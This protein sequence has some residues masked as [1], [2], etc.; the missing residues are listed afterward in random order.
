MEKSRKKI[1]ESFES[2]GHFVYRNSI[3]VLIIMTLGIGFLVS[4]LP[5]M[6]MD[7]SIEG[8]LKENS[9]VR[10]AYDAFKE[11]YGRDELILLA[12]KGKNVFTVPFLNKLQKLH[13][14]IEDTI[15]HLDDITSLVN[16]RNTYGEGDELR[17]D[18][19]LQDWDGTIDKKALE[20]LRTQAMGN[21]VYKNMLLSEDGTFTTIIVKTDAFMS[22]GQASEEDILEG[23]DVDN[24]AHSG[25]KKKLK[26]LSG[27][28]NSAIVNAI[29]KI[30]KKYSSPDF[31][32]YYAGSPV[33]EES[34]KN[35]MHKDMQKFMGLALLMISFFL[36]LMF[37]RVSGVFLPVL[38]VVL[39]LL[40]TLSLMAWFG[41]AIK[42][43]TQILPSFLLAV[44]VG[45]A[46]HIM[47]IFYRKLSHNN[48][49]KED[50]IAYALGHSGLAVVMTSLTTAGGL[51]S[52]TS[53]DLAPIADIGMYATAGVLL[54]LTY[55]IILLPALLAVIP[56][57]PKSDESIH[58]KKEAFLDRMLDRIA[59]LSTHHAKGV[60]LISGGIMII[61]FIGAL[62]LSFSHNPLTWFPK[63]DPVRIAT[64]TIDHELKGSTSLE[65][66]IKTG[67]EN[68]VY[69]PKLLAGINSF[70]EEVKSVREGS[71]FVGK[72]LAVTDILKESNKALHE[73]KEAFYTIPTNDKL[74]AQELLLFENSGSDDLEDFVD[75][76]FTEAR[77]TLKNPWLD[78]YIFPPFMQKV[79]EVLKKNIGSDVEFYLTGMM[80]L[81][82]STIHATIETMK[83]SYVVAFSIISVLMVIMLGSLKYGAVSMIPNLAPILFTLG[84]LGFVGHP[85]DLFLMLIGAIAIGLAVDDTIHFMHNFRRYHALTGDVHDAVRETLHTTGRAML[86]TTIVLSLGFF[87]FMFSSMS[88]I[89]FFGLMSGITI[90]TALVA[91]FFLAPSLMALITPTHNKTSQ[92]I[93]E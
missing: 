10:I 48:G 52:F 22:E 25:V 83:I 50:A 13:N 38:V 88:N 34:L 76:R 74:I 90:I 92:N 51:L 29:R 63:D 81:L 53:T 70:A 23:F 46:V 21:P 60:A 42:L 31:K 85:L 11:Q 55:T 7:T 66:V 78:A 41:T 2:F 67:K 93:Q 5:Q 62:Q 65:V 43:P 3:A 64:E 57:K 79:V 18:D 1:E 75:S 58:H 89:F 77:I 61:S 8:F 37:Q 27:K 35:Y 24:K 40:S 69:S 44:G 71:L 86:T 15:P 49:D 54:A 36:Y 33:V 82:G 59:Y 14:E 9:E 84:W 26:T 16:A 20:K 91:D 47:S 28:E 30:V 45:D 80:S 19:L 56:I 73:N 72:S 87:I 4:H 39:T 32:I 12:I 68:G 6:K 17:V